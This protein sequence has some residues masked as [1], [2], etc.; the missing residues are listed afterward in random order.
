MQR[1]NWKDVTENDPHINKYLQ[2]IS[3]RFLGLYLIKIKIVI[4]ISNVC[5]TVLGML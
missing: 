1:V 2:L 5:H 3:H 4:R